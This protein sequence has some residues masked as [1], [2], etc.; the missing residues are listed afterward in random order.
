[1]WL[2]AIRN[3]DGHEAI[4]DEEQ[5]FLLVFRAKGKG[6]DNITTEAIKAYITLCRNSVFPELALN[7][8]S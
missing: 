5:A 2:S 3:G 1:M 6:L 7:L 8:E 4:E